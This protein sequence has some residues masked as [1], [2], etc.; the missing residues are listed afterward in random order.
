MPCASST[1]R[2]ARCIASRARRRRRCARSKRSSVAR[3]ATARSPI[4][5]A[6]RL[7][8]YHK[9]AQ[10]SA[11]CRI[12]SLDDAGGD[13]ESLLGRV[14][15]E[16][17]DPFLDATHDGFRTA[18]ASAIKELPERERL[19]MS[20]YYDDELNL[21]EIGAVLKVTESR[22]CQLHGQALVRL[23]ARLADWRDRTGDRA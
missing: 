19:V 11:S 20:M 10:D 7:E 23:K 9:I 18:L 6:C 16:S 14:E 15:D 8:E 4:A 12:A 3:R 5:W 17:A 2:R 13:D 22:V 1:G 21:K